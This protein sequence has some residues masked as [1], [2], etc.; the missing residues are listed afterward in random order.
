MSS[1]EAAWLLSLMPTCPI[2][3]AQ[4]ACW[5]LFTSLPAMPRRQQKATS[6]WGLAE[7]WREQKRGGLVSPMFL[8]SSG[9][10]G[11]DVTP[12]CETRAKPPSVTA[13]LCVLGH[14]EQL[15]GQGFLQSLSDPLQGNSPLTWVYLLSSPN[16]ED[17][18]EQRASSTPE[19]REVEQCPARAKP[20]S[21]R[22]SRGR[23]SPSFG[24]ELGGW[25]RPELG[26]SYH[27]L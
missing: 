12:Y 19:V 1:W 16:S 24:S 27:Q 3:S 7:A 11:H 23:L 20:E 22:A 17:L 18:A 13:L 2:L 26:I 14:R 4:S 5:Q 15:E 8:L 9:Q 21:F 25:P 10:R 6:F